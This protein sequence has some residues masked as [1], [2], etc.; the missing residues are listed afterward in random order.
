MLSHLIRLG[1]LALI[2]SLFIPFGTASEPSANAN[3][4]L[5]DEVKYHLLSQSI[6]AGLSISSA[7]FIDSTGKLIESTYFRTDSSIDGFR[8]ER[9]MERRKNSTPAVERFLTS[10]SQGTPEC[11]NKSNKYRKEINVFF[12]ENSWGSGTDSTLKLEIDET[13]RTA[14]TND[15]RHSSTWYL[16]RDP[17]DM[18]IVDSTRYYAAVSPANKDARAARYV[19]Q[20]NVVADR[21]SSPAIQG[22]RSIRAAGTNLLLATTNS[23]TSL[24]KR[25]TSSAFRVIVGVSLI[26]SL[27]GN[28]LISQNIQFYT[29]PSRYNLMPRRLTVGNRDLLNQGVAQFLLKLETIGHCKFEESP[30]SVDKNYENAGVAWV[31]INKGS[32]AGIRLDDRFILSPSHLNQRQLLLGPEVLQSIVIGEVK[33]VNYHNSVIEVIA[34]EANSPFTAAIPF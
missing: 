18:E 10:I 20:V 2:L 29:S 4:L 1:I 24:T 26:D 3:E 31:R 21:G 17:Q 14:I 22:L 23:F 8:N 30:I 6:D 27:D 5:L 34:G 15:I 9:L 19:I 33:E 16:T 12:K 28:E 7:G 32:V 11:E 13:V 25:N